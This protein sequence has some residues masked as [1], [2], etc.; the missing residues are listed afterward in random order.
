VLHALE[1]LAAAVDAYALDVRLAKNEREREELWRV[2][3]DTSW[4]LK[5]SA[6]HK[7]SEDVVVPRSQVAALI[8]RCRAI[9]ARTG[10]RMPSY[11][12][13]GD[14]NLHVNFLWDDE[15]AAPRVEDAM[16]S[17]LREVVALG[18]TLSGEHGLG[19]AKARLL[20]LAHDPARLEAQRRL[21]ALFDPAGIL[22]PGKVLPPVG[23]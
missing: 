16:V 3:R 22:N 4:A 15:A 21:K 19:R 20:P 23:A 2:R 7:L 5:R 9:A 17:L 18:G 8:A 12:H 14:G 6:R 1:R 13:A 10:I 11:G